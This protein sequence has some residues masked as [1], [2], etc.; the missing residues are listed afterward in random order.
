MM[1]EK[2]HIAVLDDHTLFRS[3]L[4]KLMNEFDELEVCFQ[5]S[6]GIAFQEQINRFPQ[7]QLVLMDINMPVMDGYQTTKWIK[8]HQPHIHVLA[9]SM[10]EDE[11]AIID[12]L[13][14]G[15][16]GYLLK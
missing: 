3:G 1:T 16:G 6:N 2:I 11:K 13:K 15:A 7:V 5:A 9:L 4:A 10:Y 12:M 14:S 8:I